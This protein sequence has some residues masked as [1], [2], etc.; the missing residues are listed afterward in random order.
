MAPQGST[1]MRLTRSF[2]H[3]DVR[4]VIFSVGCRHGVCGELHS[5]SDVAMGF[6]GCGP[7]FSASRGS[8][9]KKK[10]NDWGKEVHRKSV[11]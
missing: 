6:R 1:L 8:G 3:E 2:L 11:K 5:V 7:G 10:K 4:K 9:I